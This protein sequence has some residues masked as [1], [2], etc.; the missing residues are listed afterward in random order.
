M[1]REELAAI[2]ARLAAAANYSAEFSVDDAR[3]SWYAYT[4]DFVVPEG[5][6]VESDEAGGRPLEW[7]RRADA[8]ADTAVLYLHGGGYVCGSA[9]S[10]RPI[11]SALAQVFAGGVASLDYRL[12]P[13]DPF[14]AAVDDAV[15]AVRSIV[16]RGI[17]PGRLAIA[18]E[19]AGGGLAV[20]TLLALRDSGGP[21]PGAAW[22]ISPWAD[23]TNSGATVRE[24]TGRDPI[25]FP[26]AIDVT[27]RLY[28]GGS[29]ATH[30]QASP[31]F[32][33]LRGLPPL[34][35]QVGSSEIL[36]DDAVR[37]ARTAGLA[38]VDVTLEIW[39]EML[40][41]WHIFAGEL[42]EGR[43]ATLQAARW[44]ER[45]LRR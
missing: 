21:M 11:T 38:D 17:A 35:I 34:L 8:A 44:L 23:L 37:L 27:A 15:A 28:L 33:D 32:A 40:H 18:G 43:D 36:V 12:A 30:P 10:H 26:G 41:A 20:A 24:S 13:E 2:R 14:P 7:I 39:P 9:R 4:D 22:C 31:I 19:S 6:K 3:V 25:V 1:S 16:S 5:L 29:P 42:S 45:H